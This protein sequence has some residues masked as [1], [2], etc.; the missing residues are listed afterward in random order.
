M[1]KNWN[2]VYILLGLPSHSEV[3]KAVAY[4]KILLYMKKK[5]SINEGKV[6]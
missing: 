4:W 2:Y 3:K 6:Y 5:K 1:I